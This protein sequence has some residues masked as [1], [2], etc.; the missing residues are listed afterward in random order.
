MAA[1]GKQISSLH[2]DSMDAASV[3]L[4]VA[5]RAIVEEL[6]PHAVYRYQG[7]AQASKG[8]LLASGTITMTMSTS[9]L[10]DYFTTATATGFPFY[11]Y[12]TVITWDDYTVLRAVKDCVV[13][14]TVSGRSGVNEH[15]YVL[16]TV[17]L[18]SNVQADVKTLHAS[19]GA[20]GKVNAAAYL[21]LEED[22]YLAVYTGGGGNGEVWDTFIVAEDMPPT[23]AV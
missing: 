22:D 9:P 8:N 1:Y 11:N 21:Y 15:I 17:N 2:V 7:D 4:A 14:V 10:S 12:G 23:I 16:Q 5:P 3:E 20:I 13:R 18:N 19:P 6:R